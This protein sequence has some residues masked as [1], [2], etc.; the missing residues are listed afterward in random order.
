[1]SFISITKKNDPNKKA[2]FKGNPKDKKRVDNLT[3]PTPSE[4]RNRGI[5]YSA[6]ITYDFCHEKY[7]RMETGEWKL[8]SEI[9]YYENVAIG[10][11]D[12]YL[13]SKRTKVNCY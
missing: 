3:I 5:T 12:L 7:K 1:M 4:C 8:F 2:S 6:P 9:K 11:I 13:Q 10:I